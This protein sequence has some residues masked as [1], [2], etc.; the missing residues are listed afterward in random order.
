MDERRREHFRAL[1]RKGGRATVD[2]YGKEHMRELGRL[3]FTGG[4][5]GVAHAKLLAAGKLPPG[6]R[7]LSVA[8][9][10]RLLD[11]LLAPPDADGDP[12]PD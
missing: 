9:S 8:E 6:R 5:R 4:G 7:P 1:G 2:K 10:A 12:R 3:G 11:E